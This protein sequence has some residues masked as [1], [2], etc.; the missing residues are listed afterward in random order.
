MGYSSKIENV[1]LCLSALENVFSD[2]GRKTDSG[3]AESAAHKSY[4]ANP[5]SLPQ[6]MSLPLHRK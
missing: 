3:A 1:M 6:Q 5:L 4:A 2:M